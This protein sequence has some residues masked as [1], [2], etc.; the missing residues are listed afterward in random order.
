MQFCLGPVYSDCD[1]GSCV[2]HWVSESGE[3]GQSGAEWG[4]VREGQGGEGG[5]I[6]S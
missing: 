6:S 2:Q 3:T 1:R 4:R 5:G